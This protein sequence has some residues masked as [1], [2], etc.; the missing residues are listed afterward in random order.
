MTTRAANGRVWTLLQHGLAMALIAVLPHFLARNAWT[1]L[2]MLG[3]ER[4]IAPALLAYALTAGFIA[5]RRSRPGSLSGVGVVAVVSAAMLAGLLAVVAVLGLYGAGTFDQSTPLTMKAVLVVIVVAAGLG[6]SVNLFA[7]ARWLTAVLL[8]AVLG[9]GFGVW[10]SR[11]VAVADDTEERSA[12]IRVR[13]ADSAYYVL[14]LTEYRYWIP[15]PS[16]SGG[17]ILRF[18]THNLLAT[19]DGDLYLFSEKTTRDGLDIRKLQTR[20]PINAEELRSDVAANV[21]TQYFRVA[22][23]VATPKGGGLRLYASHHY[24]KHGPGCFVVRVSY[25]DWTAQMV[26]APESA[27]PSWHT[28]YESAPCLRTTDI[29]APEYTG[30]ME[31][32]G[33]MLVLDDRHLLLTIGDHEFEGVHSS[34]VFAQMP[35]V[36]YGKTVIIDLEDGSW[37]LFTMGHRNPQGLLRLDDGTIFASEHGPQGGDELNILV[38]GKNYGWPEVT[39]G[40][41]YGLHTWERNPRQGS[42]VG[43]QRPLFAWVPSVGISDLVEVR[44]AQFDLW[45]GDILA[46]SLKGKSLWRMH[47]REGRVIYDEPISIGSKIRDILELEGGRLLLWTDRD[48]VFVEAAADRNRGE[49]HFAICARCH[50]TDREPDSHGIGPNLFGVV[51][52]RVASSERY[53][54]SDAMRQ[55]KGVWSR[56]RLERFLEA[57]GKVVPGTTMNVPGVSDSESRRQIVEFLSGLEDARR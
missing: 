56:E 40:T 42:H 46:G 27:A 33:E 21:L 37:Q 23:I 49:T 47:L 29:H 1:S 35:A 41:D 34:D 19:G 4:L 28:L 6:V 17:G 54:Y 14:K 20:V 9:S 18:G 38:A 45:K 26:A 13:Y 39:Y 30:F 48:L 43:Y 36:P 53:E 10:Q 25:S 57:P 12:G 5:W 31:S 16:S 11:R 3:R 22:D 24:W 55:Q 7:P 50:T 51:G 52:R 8:L 44:G 2:T 32:G 15:T